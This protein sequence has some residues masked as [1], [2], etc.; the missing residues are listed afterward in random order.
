MATSEGGRSSLGGATR[1]GAGRGRMTAGPALSPAAWLRFD[2]VRA[3][4]ERPAPRRVL[5]VGPGKRRDR[6]R[7]VAAGHD[8]T[9]VERSPASR[10]STSALLA[11]IPGRGRVV[12][13][14]E[15]VA[16][17][18]QF[19]LLC[20]FEVLEH[21]EDDA[22]ALREWAAWL[23]PGGNVLLS[24]PA[25]PDRFSCTDAEVGHLRRYT[26]EGIAALAE[27][28]GLADV[29]VRLYGFP[30]GYLLDRAREVLARRAERGRRATAGPSTVERTERSG[31]WYQP[32]ALVQ[33]GRPLGHGTLPLDA[34]AGRRPGN[35]LGPEHASS[36]AVTASPWPRR[37]PDPSA[38]AVDGDPVVRHVLVVNQH[39]DNTGD[40]AALRAMLDGLADR[41]GPV[42]FTVLHQFREASSCI[43]TTHDVTWQRLVLPAGAPSGW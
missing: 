9:G 34:T 40:E 21:I 31:A 2:V 7:L 6:A 30:L 1:R 29:Q 19:D 35:G 10:R 27:Q 12:E 43:E 8:Y 3:E 17:T 22:G 14:F 36:F 5:E 38:P 25:W 24:V 42:R 41:L 20:A 33:R 28:A 11:T 32:P 18:E 16:W 37:R 26:P 15:D 13:S 39:G 4:L 23:R